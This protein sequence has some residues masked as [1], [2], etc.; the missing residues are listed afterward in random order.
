MPS[1]TKVLNALAQASTNSL[2]PYGQKDE[3]ASG[4]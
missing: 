2:M 1:F 3:L 4:A